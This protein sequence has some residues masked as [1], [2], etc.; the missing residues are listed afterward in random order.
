MPRSHWNVASTYG[1]AHLWVLRS[2][3][4]LIL[5]VKTGQLLTAAGTPL[6]QLVFREGCTSIRA[7][8]LRTLQSSV[9][10][11]LKQIIFT[12]P[13]DVGH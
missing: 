2:Q 7:L 3:N 1:S 12:S 11:F 6:L 13:N 5:G 8:F 9:F 10:S 4:A